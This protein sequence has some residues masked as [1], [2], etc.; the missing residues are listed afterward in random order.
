MFLFLL[1]CHYVRFD[2]TG[3]KLVTRDILR[4]VKND[5]PNIKEEEVQCKCV[6]QGSDTH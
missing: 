5:S 2:S 4:E 3:N 1:Q 6:S